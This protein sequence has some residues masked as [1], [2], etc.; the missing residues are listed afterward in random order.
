MV[1]EIEKLKANIKLEKEDANNWKKEYETTNEQ[2]KN[3]QSIHKAYFK[4]FNTLI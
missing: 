2:S 3:E 4:S 1:S